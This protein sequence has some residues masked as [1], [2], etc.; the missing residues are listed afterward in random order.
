METFPGSDGPVKL[1][2]SQDYNMETCGEQMRLFVNMLDASR[3]THHG[4]ELRVVGLC[5]TKDV[6]GV[7]DLH[8]ETWQPTGNA[9]P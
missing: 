7:H 6:G 2:E 8:R 1:K 3:R 5:D 9:G 4:I